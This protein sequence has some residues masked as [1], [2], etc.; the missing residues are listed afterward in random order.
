[1]FIS[2]RSS[3]YETMKLSLNINFKDFTTLNNLDVLYPALKKEILILFLRILS[4]LSALFIMLNLY[5]KIFFF[6]KKKLL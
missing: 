3:P 5:F 1:M 2:D 4:L 6:D